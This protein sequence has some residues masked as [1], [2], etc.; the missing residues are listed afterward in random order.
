MINSAKTTKAA[1][2]KGRGDSESAEG[3]VE[4]WT[5]YIDDTCNDT[6]SGAGMMFINPE[7]HKIH[8]AVHFGFKALNNKAEYKAL[9]LGLRLACKLQVRNM[10]IFNDSQLAVNQVN[11][12]YLVKGEKMAAYLD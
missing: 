11:D 6:G 8:Y 9:I 7:G 2:V 4:Q 5:L 10:K 3:D 1:G 12:I